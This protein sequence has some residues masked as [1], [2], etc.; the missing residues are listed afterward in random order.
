MSVSGDETSPP[1][2]FIPMLTNTRTFGNVEL[3]PAPLTSATA[4]PFWPKPEIL[5]TRSA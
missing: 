5:T 3:M 4:P 1:A 2:W